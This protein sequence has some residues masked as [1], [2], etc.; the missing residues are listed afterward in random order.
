[1]TD[2]NSQGRVIF[3]V[4]CRHWQSRPS[5]T[6]GINKWMRGSNCKLTI[7]SSLSDIHCGLLQIVGLIK[8]S[9]VRPLWSDLCILF[10]L[11]IL[12]PRL[13]TPKE[14]IDPAAFRSRSDHEAEHQCRVKSGGHVPETAT[15]TSRP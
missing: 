1:M 5:V 4:V 15:N 6:E 10:V 11:F 7:R 13:L 9:E 8:I 14:S 3:T 12:A 2:E